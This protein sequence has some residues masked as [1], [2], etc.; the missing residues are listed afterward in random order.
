MIRTTAILMTKSEAQKFLSAIDRLESELPDPDVH[1]LL[2]KAEL[3]GLRSQWQ[4]LEKSSANTRRCALASKRC[5]PSVR[6][7]IFRSD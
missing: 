5:R 7:K 4:E 6:Y 1:P 2:A 3:D